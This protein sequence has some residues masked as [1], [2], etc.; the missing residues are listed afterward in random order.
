MTNHPLDERTIRFKFHPSICLEL[1]RRLQTH[2]LYSYAIDLLSKNKC[3][4]DFQLTFSNEKV[5][6]SSRD[7]A[8][9]SHRTWQIYN[10]LCVTTAICILSNDITSTRR[11]FHRWFTIDSLKHEIVMDFFYFLL[12]LFTCANRLYQL[13]FRSVEAVWLDVLP[14]T[15]PW[16][17]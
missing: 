2:P 10:P 13:Q 7:N 3:T 16:S 8:L 12:T 4:D 17:V 9:L 11:L 14:L 6:P 1:H 15:D 5:T